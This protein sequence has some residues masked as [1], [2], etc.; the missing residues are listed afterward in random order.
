MTSPNIIKT[1]PAESGG[2]AAAVVV[3]I[4]YFLGVDDPGVFAALV[5]VVGALPAVITWIVELVKKS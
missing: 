3:L 1:R 2:L 5:I 4:A